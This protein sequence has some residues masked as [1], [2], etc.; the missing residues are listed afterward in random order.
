MKLLIIE[1]EKS[2]ADSICEYFHQEG[3]ICEKV[4]SLSKADEKIC[5]YKYDCIIVDIGLPD[6]SGLEIINKLKQKKSETGIIIVSARNALSDKIDGLEIGADDYLTKPFHLSELNARLK[7]VIRRRNFNGNNEIVCNEII[8]YPDSMEVLV[9]KKPVALTKKELDLLLF[10]IVNKNRVVTK[11]SIAE[12]LWGDN[13]D[14]VDSYDFIYTHIKNLRRK[15]IEQGC[16]DYIQ[17][18]Y[19]MGYKFNLTI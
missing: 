18:V 2:L 8:I 6:G 4:E 15:L 19:G 7:S 11:E 10:F 12:H 3:H 5:L 17:T 1:D 14:L 13:Y 9:N 16:T